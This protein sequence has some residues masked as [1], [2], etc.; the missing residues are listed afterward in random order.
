MS[1]GAFEYNQRRIQD[2]IEGIEGEIERSNNGKPKNGIIE[3]NKERDDCVSGSRSKY[4]LKKVI[5]EFSEKNK[6]PYLIALCLCLPFKNGQIQ[7]H[8]QQS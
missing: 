7:S 5:P 6:D 3:I 1:G 4:K 8:H 2:I